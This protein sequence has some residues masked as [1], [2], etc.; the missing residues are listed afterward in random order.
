MH[1]QVQRNTP[2]FFFIYNALTSYVPTTN[3]SP[4]CHIYATDAN[5]FMCTHETAMSVYITHMNSLQ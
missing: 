1:I 4:K 3:M 2:I 5:Y